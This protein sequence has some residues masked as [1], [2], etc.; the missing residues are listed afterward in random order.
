EDG[1]QVEAP[2]IERIIEHSDIEDPEVRRQVMVL[3][4]HRSVQQSLIKSGA[5]IGQKIITGRMEWYL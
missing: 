1:W 5:V 3:L 2:E 4:K